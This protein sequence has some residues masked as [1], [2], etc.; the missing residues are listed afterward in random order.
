MGE[1]ANIFYRI[2]CL[3]VQLKEP[4]PHLASQAMWSEVHQAIDIVKEC[5]VTVTL[6]FNLVSI[7]IHVAGSSNLLS[8]FMFLVVKF[9]YRKNLQNQLGTNSYPSL[10]TNIVFTSP[11]IPENAP[12]KEI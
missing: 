2:L 12:Q 1:K 5:H 6:I 10:P 9:K 3:Q 4:E 7:S 8:V 11:L